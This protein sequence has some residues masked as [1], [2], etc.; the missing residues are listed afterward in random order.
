MKILRIEDREKTVFNEFAASYGTIFNTSNW[1]DMF[2]D[3]VE[4]C[5][6]YNNGGELMGG[7]VTYKEKRYG[8]SFYRN[9]P[10]T[11][12]LGPFLKVDAANPVSI[13]DI[14]KEVLLEMSQFFENLRFS[15]ISI[16]L[17]KNIIDTQP[18]IWK[19]FKVVPGYTYVIDL[20]MSAETIW[21]GMSSERRKNIKKGG[22]DGL[23]VRKVTDNTIIRE[24]VMKTYSR[25]DKEA[26]ERYLDK[27]LFGFA[28]SHNSFAYATYDGS[29]AI[30]C[31]FCVYDTHT[32]YYILGGYDFENKHHG[33]GAMSMWE[34]IKNAQQLGLRDFDFEGSMVPQIERYFR[35][36]GGR[37]TPYFTINKAL[38]PLEVILKYFKR[39]LF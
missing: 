29:K 17:N 36:F 34:A 22:K 33:A 16:S 14:W 13:M 5:G 18:F 30:A 15:V 12:V 38:F 10:Y 28:D 35:G 9:P 24:L 11:P 3:K 23:V 27:I 7:F 6:I 21:N 4:L 31:V 1:L 26:N 39:E 2:G 32:A 37:L 8:L 19:K 20:S 25:Q